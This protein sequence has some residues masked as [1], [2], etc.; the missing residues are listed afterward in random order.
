MK[1]VSE[2]TYKRRLAKAITLAAWKHGAYYK[3]MK[4][5]RANYV[6]GQVIGTSVQGMLTTK[7][8]VLD[9]TALEDGYG[10]PICAS[11][12]K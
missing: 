4:L 9:E 10:R 1:R 3:G 12:F 6:K 11:H 8:V 7:T 5:M 2:D